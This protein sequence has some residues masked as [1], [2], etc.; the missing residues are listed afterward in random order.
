MDSN[1]IIHR[2]FQIVFCQIRKTKS[3]LRRSKA[4]V[5]LVRKLALEYT[6]LAAAR[7]NARYIC[8]ATA[9]D[10]S[11]TRYYSRCERMQHRMQFHTLGSS[12]NRANDCNERSH[13]LWP[14]QKRQTRF[15]PWTSWP[16]NSQT[17]D[18]SEH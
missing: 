16:T 18:P 3:Y 14:C 17:V 1:E 9:S 10:F 7:M 2:H 13:G 6:A 5:S 12:V 8:R 15:G 4:E 11:L